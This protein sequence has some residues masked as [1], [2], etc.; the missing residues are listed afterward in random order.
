MSRDTNI[1]AI[2]RFLL[3]CGKEENYFKG[4]AL[5]SDAFPDS[6][7]TVV[8][9]STFFCFCFWTQPHAL[10]YEFYIKTLWCQPTAGG[11]I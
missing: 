11:Q 5:E 8:C 6:L 1:S 2:Y 9:G 10:D 7:E 3:L 4:S